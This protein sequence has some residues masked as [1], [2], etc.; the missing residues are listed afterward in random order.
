MP[1]SGPHCWILSLCYTCALY[2]LYCWHNLFA[3]WQDKWSLQDSNLSGSILFALKFFQVNL[4][5]HQSCHWFVLPL[6]EE[7]VC[8]RKNRTHFDN[9]YIS[10]LNHSLFY[11]IFICMSLRVK[12]SVGI[13]IVI[14]PTWYLFINCS[15]WIVLGIFYFCVVHNGHLV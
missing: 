10:S 3:W 8:C 13:Y 11:C 9:L 7:I 2:L 1:L 5:N 12:H 15:F 4:F 6:S 14:C